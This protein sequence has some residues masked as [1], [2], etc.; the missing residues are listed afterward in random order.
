MFT[1]PFEHRET[2]QEH[3]FDDINRTTRDRTNNET[4][5]EFSNEDENNNA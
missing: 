1:L 4:N 3:I 2:S 5:V